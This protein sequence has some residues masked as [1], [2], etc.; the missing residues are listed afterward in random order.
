MGTYQHRKIWVKKY[1]EKRNQ[2]R[3]R[4]Y[5][6]SRAN[7]RLKSMKHWKNEELALIFSKNRPCDRELSRIIGRS[8]Q[9]I[10]SA[11]LRW[12]SRLKE[13]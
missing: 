4:N 3:Q 10:Q 11:R 2:Q 1:P 7:G 8:V 5:A 12:K 6:K 9:S 13:R